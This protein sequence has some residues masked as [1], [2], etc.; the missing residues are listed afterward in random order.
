MLCFC[1]VHNI[2][3][4]MVIKTKGVEFMPFFRRP[5]D[6]RSGHTL[7][8]AGASSRS[9]AGGLVDLRMDEAAATPSDVV[10]VLKHSGTCLRRRVRL[11]VHGR[12]RIPT[13]FSFF[14]R[15]GRLSTRFVGCEINGICGFD[16]VVFG[17]R[18]SIARSMG[19]VGCENNILGLNYP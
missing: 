13:H 18:I 14:D 4:R 10:A 8:S 9:E 19:F 15:F 3:K 1:K 11:A 7:V 5:S 17:G 6:L 12:R 2:R 16:L